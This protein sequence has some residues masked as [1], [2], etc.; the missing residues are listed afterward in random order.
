MPQF[1]RVG[2][3]HTAEMPRRRQPRFWEARGWA[4]VRIHRGATCPEST[5]RRARKV[6]LMAGLQSAFRS[7]TGVF[8]DNINGNLAS[9]MA[10][11]ATSMPLQNVV[12]TPA[13]AQ[14]A[15]IVDGPLTEQVAVSAYN[16]G[17]HTA[18]V[19]ATAKQLTSPT[20]MSFSR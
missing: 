14:T 17:T 2:Y 13:T 15:L 20:S 16:A 19:A 3:D 1:K 4:R 18:T 12:G 10:A 6:N 8:K 7:F 5:G 11:A 9:N